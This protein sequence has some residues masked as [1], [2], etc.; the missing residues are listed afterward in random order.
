MKE[1]KRHEEGIDNVIV[2]L[3]AGS[4]LIITT[5]LRGGRQGR[6]VTHLPCGGHMDLELCY[7]WDNL[8]P[9]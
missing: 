8:Y 9:H 3:P 1:V 6:A 4:H 5:C 7:G 2:L